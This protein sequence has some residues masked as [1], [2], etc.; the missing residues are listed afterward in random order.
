M[1][2]RVVNA[3]SSVDFPTVDTDLVSPS[4]LTNVPNRCAYS[5]ISVDRGTRQPWQLCW[6]N[7]AFLPG[8]AEILGFKVQD[9]VARPKVTDN[10]KSSWLVTIPHFPLWNCQ[11]KDF[12]SIDLPAWAQAEVL[13][14]TEIAQGRQR[15]GN[16]GLHQSPRPG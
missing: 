3:I 4:S 1:P 8:R 15:V 9:G 2:W 14:S 7:D 16:N 12:A 11:P 10:L 5:S 6:R 13:M